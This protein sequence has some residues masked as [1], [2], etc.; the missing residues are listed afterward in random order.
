MLR[1]RSL[2]VLWAVV[3]LAGCYYYQVVP[4]AGL[5]PK[6]Q[7][8]VTTRDGHLEELTEVTVASDTVCGVRNAQR[9]LWS[10]H[11][12]VAIAVAD[13]TMVEGQ[14][15]DLASSVVAGVAGVGLATV[16]VTGALLWLIS[17]AIGPR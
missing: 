11:G 12:S 5:A 6:S 13:I 15:L 3:A 8:R 14:R 1:I 17:G 16:A 7:V 9:W 2:G 10:R 4:L